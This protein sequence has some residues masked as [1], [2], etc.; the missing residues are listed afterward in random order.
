MDLVQVSRMLSP[1]LDQF[2]LSSS[3]VPLV[4]SRRRRKRGCQPVPLPVVLIRTPS[5]S[6][7]HQPREKGPHVVACGVMH[8]LLQLAES[9]TTGFV[10]QGSNKQAQQGTVRN[11]DL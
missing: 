9:G 5:V 1:P 2:S 11:L 6:H 8:H 3:Y 4:P 7:Q 10:R